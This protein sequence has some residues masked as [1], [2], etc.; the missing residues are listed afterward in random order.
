LFGKAAVND[1]D[2][3]IYGFRLFAWHRKQAGNR[4]G[5]AYRWVATKPVPAPWG[6]ICHTV[7]RIS[8]AM[9]AAN[10]GDF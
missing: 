5:N 3:A 4:F 6:G 10:R 7:A 2:H 8:V 9:K 1:K